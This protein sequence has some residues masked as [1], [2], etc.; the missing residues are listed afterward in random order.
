MTLFY[1][2]VQNNRNKTLYSYNPSAVT[3]SSV[4]AVTGSS[5]GAEP[6]FQKNEN[7]NENANVIVNEN[8]PKTGIKN[9][10]KEFNPMGN[11]LKTMYE[12]TTKR[13]SIIIKRLDKLEN[14][15]LIILIILALI[16]IKLY[17]K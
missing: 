8:K 17:E 9:N 3:G 11:T 6:R 14:F 4:G 15:M 1:S 7:E 10:S 2:N 13:H 5:V 12:N 16:A